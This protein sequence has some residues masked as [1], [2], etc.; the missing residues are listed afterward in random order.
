VKVKIL[1]LAAILSVACLAVHA[2][3]T[4][5]SNEDARAEQILRHMTLE[6]KL[7]LIRGK[8]PFQLRPSDRRT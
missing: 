1:T 7:A 6:E 2:A 8:Q 3:A 5:A 4:N